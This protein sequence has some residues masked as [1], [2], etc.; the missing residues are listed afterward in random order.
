MI[1]VVFGWVT[2][3]QLEWNVIDTLMFWLFVIA[4]LVIIEVFKELKDKKKK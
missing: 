1:K 3:G 2:K 4:V